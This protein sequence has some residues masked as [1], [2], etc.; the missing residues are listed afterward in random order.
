MSKILG[1]VNLGLNCVN[2]VANICEGVEISKNRDAIYRVAQAVDVTQQQN[3]TRFE[4]MNARINRSNENNFDNR[5]KINTLNNKL[6]SVASMK[7]TTTTTELKVN[8]SDGGLKEML[9]KLLGE[10]N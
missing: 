3:N 5:M 7:A 4:N 9:K 2:G 8:D 6:N 1:L 10:N